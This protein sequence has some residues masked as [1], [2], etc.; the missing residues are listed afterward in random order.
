MN[1]LICLFDSHGPQVQNG[2]RMKWSK[3]L[4]LGTA[5]RPWGASAIVRVK[6]ED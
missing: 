4:D 2:V 6:K 5:R 1:H 3:K